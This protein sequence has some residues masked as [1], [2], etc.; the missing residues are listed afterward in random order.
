MPADHHVTD[1]RELDIT[2]LTTGGQQGLD[3]TWRAEPWYG[4]RIAEFA[5]QYGPGILRNL[6]VHEQQRSRL[7]HLRQGRMI[8]QDSVPITLPKGKSRSQM[9]GFVNRGAVVTD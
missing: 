5:G 2:S 8:R 4:P 7:Q 9:R 6:D 3:R 1:G